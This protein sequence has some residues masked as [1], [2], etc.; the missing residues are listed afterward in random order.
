M[1]LM[2]GIGIAVQAGHPVRVQPFWVTSASAACT[3]TL[4]AGGCSCSA[5]CSPSGAP[6]V[7]TKGTGDEIDAQSPRTAPGGV[8]ASER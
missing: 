8:Q 3:R 4:A 1:G 7:R 5:A 6:K 2:I